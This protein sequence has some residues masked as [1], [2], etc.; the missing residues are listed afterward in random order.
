MPDN[1]VAGM[2]EDFVAA[3]VPDGDQ[4]MPAAKEAVANAVAI[5]APFKG[6]HIAKAEIHTWLAWQDEPGTPLGLA[7]TKKY[8]N[9]EA[10]SAASFL[11]WLH[12]LFDA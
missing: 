7:I 9:P 2:L 6:I 11:K 10:E 4:V 5:P 8:L 1:T 12:D 3:L